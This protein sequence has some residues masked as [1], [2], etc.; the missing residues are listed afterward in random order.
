M[1][2]SPSLYDRMDLSWAKTDTKLGTRFY[3]N[4]SLTYDTNLLP[5]IKGLARLFSR[6]TKDKLWPLVI[7]TTFGAAAHVWQH[8]RSGVVV[9]TALLPTSEEEPSSLSQPTASWSRLNTVGAIAWHH[10]CHP[11]CIAVSGLTVNWNETLTITFRGILV[12]LPFNLRYYEFHRCYGE[13]LKSSFPFVG[14]IFRFWV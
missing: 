10:I 5:A 13:E 6:L 8:V 12:A 14:G 9:G 7:Q 3:T 11:G 2:A 4:R 1:I